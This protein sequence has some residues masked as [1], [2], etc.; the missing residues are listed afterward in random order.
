M[1]NFS[2]DEALEKSN[3]LQDIVSREVWETVYRGNDKTCNFFDSLWTRNIKKNAR[4]YYKKCG[5]VSDLAGLG[6]NKA[7]I[8]IGAGPSLKNNIDILKALS[9]QDGTRP[10]HQQDFILIASNHQFKPCL[11]QGIIPHFVILCDAGP[12]LKDQLCK[13]I[14]ENGQYT[15]LLSTLQADPKIIREWLNQGRKVKFFIG[16][17]GVS[18]LAARITKTDKKN[19]ETV[20][21]GN[22]LNNIWTLAC[23]HLGSTVFMCVG[24]DLSFERKESVEEQRQSFYADGD[25]ST[26]KASKRDEAAQKYDWMGF[27]FY[28]NVVSP[29]GKPLIRLEPVRT[30]SQFLVYKIWLESAI[31]MN[32]TQGMS[33]RYYN[34]SEGGILG[35]KCKEDKGEGMF[36]KDN[37]FLL[38]EL[39]PKRWCTRRLK[40]AI[41]EFIT[42]KTLLNRRI[43]AP[44]QC[45]QVSAL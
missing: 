23:T 41:V 16:T 28:D 37:W 7:A 30:T 4:R 2:Y 10:F 25:Y 6:K 39:L 33:F 12:H 36:N 35:V 5:P 14:P 22:V 42:A 17:E 21:G 24:N 26:N 19:L 44:T 15:I 3:K 34:C 1:A 45:C 40:D 8:G 18:D 43:Y 27:S 29:D 9:L 20:S 38:D 31:A 32:A 13:D 11:N